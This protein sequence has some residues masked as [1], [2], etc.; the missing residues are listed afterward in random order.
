MTTLHIF[1]LKIE[2]VSAAVE[3]V[4]DALAVQALSR[5]LSDNVEASTHEYRL[6]KR[7]SEGIGRDYRVA[8]NSLL[9]SAWG[10][11]EDYVR[12]VLP[13]MAK[14][15]TKAEITRAACPDNLF[16]SN[17][18]VTAEALRD[19]VG[20]SA[21]RAYE[22][23]RMSSEF[24]EGFRK[25]GKILFNDQGMGKIDGKFAI[26]DLN[27]Y[28]G[29]LV[30]KLKWQDVGQSKDIQKFFDVSSKT[31]AGQKSESLLKEVIKDRNKIA[32][33]GAG[34]TLDTLEPIGRLVTF[35]R[36]F[37]EQLD[38]LLRVHVASLA[39]RR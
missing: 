22:L 31:A 12:G 38:A 39:S 36:L 5:T 35:L 23:E 19:S 14:E 9:V 2:E 1:S 28:L 8:K 33:Q 13:E 21:L 10:C 18:Y 27:C 11:V 6:L 17:I 29:R 3:F 24:A 34:T 32:H 37:V 20:G 30:F 15:L 25:D 7:L 16:N 26:E 4:E